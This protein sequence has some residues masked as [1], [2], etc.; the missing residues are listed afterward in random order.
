MNINHIS[1]KSKELGLSIPRLGTS[2]WVADEVLKNSIS[3]GSLFTISNPEI[4]DDFSEKIKMLKGFENLNLNIVSIYAYD[5]LK[6]IIEAIKTAGSLGGDKIK[7]AMIN[8]SISGLSNSE[9]S[10][11]SDRELKNVN[12]SIM[13]IKNGKSVLY[14]SE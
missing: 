8:I 1:K 4:S 2:A 9:I 11:G 10:F 5:A 7:N 6:T 3:E 12:M 13:E 14:I